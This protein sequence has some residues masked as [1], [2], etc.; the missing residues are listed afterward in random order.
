MSVGRWTAEYALLRGLE[1]LEVFPGDDIGARNNLRRRFW[2]YA[3]AKA[4][5]CAEHPPPTVRVRGR[6]G[7]RRVRAADCT[8]CGVGGGADSAGVDQRIGGAP[9]VRAADR[10]ASATM[11]TAEPTH[12]MQIASSLAT[13]TYV[14]HAEN[15]APR[16]RGTPSRR[17][18]ARRRAAV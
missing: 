8:R 2:R 3:V 6:S 4:S 7:D 11:H 1:R 14:S 13:S 10:P 18:P 17:V 9:S 16:T 15:P 12:Q 5:R